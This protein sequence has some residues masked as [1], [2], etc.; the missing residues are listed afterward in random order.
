MPIVVR[1]IAA[2]DTH[3]L[4][5]RALRPHQRVEEMI[6]PH[7]DDADTVHFGAFD[8]ERLAGVATIYHEGIPDDARPGDWR[9][10]GM[11]V[12][13][14]RR[15]GG[16]GSLLLR[17][18]GR[19]IAANGGDRLWCHART[20]ARRFYER[21]GLTARGEEYDGGDIGPHVIMAGTIA[22]LLAAGDGTR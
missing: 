7:D 18:C 10:R 13:D 21:H 20:P 12:D 9:L 5:Q 8:G 15:G 6:Y 1:L 4:R 14:E 3:D 22:D 17:A 2:A 19:H 11:A 16:V